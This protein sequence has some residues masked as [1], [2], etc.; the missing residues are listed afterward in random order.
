MEALMPPLSNP[1]RHQVDGHGVGWR[2]LCALL[3]VLVVVLPALDLAWGEMP[4]HGHPC[5]LHTALMLAPAGVAPAAPRPSSAPIVGDPAG[6]L[7]GFTPS[8]F[9]PPRP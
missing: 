6:S 9:I 5:P 1:A 4:R 3:M 7:P 2:V 8:I